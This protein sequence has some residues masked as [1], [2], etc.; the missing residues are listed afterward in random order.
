MWNVGAIGG[1]AV[2]KTGEW[3]QG[4]GTVKRDIGGLRKNFSGLGASISAA[5]TQISM[6]G[7]AAQVGMGL[8]VHEAMKVEEAE[9]LFEV[10]FGNMAGDVREWSESVHDSMLMTAAE[11]REGAGV[12]A[13][14]TQS[15]GLSGE[16]SAS[17]SK[18][19]TMLAADMA[20]FYNLPHEDALQKLQA[21][22]TGEAEPLKRL[23]ILVNE[24]TT[25]HWAWKNGVVAVGQELSEQQKVIARYGAIMEQT[26]KA[27][28]DLLRTSDSTT[29]Q[30][31]QM[32]MQFK[33]L[34]TEL[35][36]NLLPTI[37][38]G[39]SLVNVIMEKSQ[40]WYEVNAD[41]A[42]SLTVA[43]AG[44]LNAGG[45]ARG[46]Q[47]KRRPHRARRGGGDT[48]GN[49][50]GPIQHQQELD[51]IRRRVC[52]RES[53]AF[54]LWFVGFERE[55]KDIWVPR[56]VRASIPEVGPENKAVLSQH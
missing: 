39:G 25:K 6:L 20:S 40:K 11:V 27:Q 9:N 22:L 33:E 44:A 46:Y 5:A 31:R 54:G 30:L 26:G 18:N 29:N 13:V 3:S 8:A 4:V 15:M 41:V 36:T 42:Q 35:A 17:L 53:R 37:N 32:R 2:L 14:M 48:R 23:G 50:G 19:M 1:K 21:G 56:F 45:R 38:M 47:A 28:G 7:A 43:G 52:L 55:R 51:G 16:V 12:F 34:Y 24:T 49:R 10:S